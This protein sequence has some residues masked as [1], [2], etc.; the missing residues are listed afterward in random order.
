VIRT[1][2][3][4]ITTLYF[5]NL[6]RAWSQNGY[7]AKIFPELLQGIL[8]MLGL[9]ALDLLRLEELLADPNAPTLLW[10][11]GS[12]CTG[13]SVSFLNYIET[14][15]TGPV[16]AADV[17]IKKVNLA[18]HQTV[19]DVSGETAVNV[20]DSVYASNNYYLVVEGG[21]PSAYGGHTCLAWTRNGNTDVT[22]LEAVRALAGR[23]LGILSIGT[24]ASWGGVS[25]AAPNL[26][27]VQGVGAAT[28]KPTVNIAGCPPHPNW[29][30]WGIVRALTGTVGTLDAYRRP[31]Q[32]YRSRVHDRCPR[33]ER[34]EAS[35]YGQ[36]GRC[37]EE[38]G[39]LGPACRA[40]SR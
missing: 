32:L 31:T 18:F 11:Q 28:G 25:A 26:T 20:V 24:C 17:L 39:C 21:V 8:M 14:S 15:T 2:A 22:F 16:T 19:M 34:E 4:A 13:C 5:T 37:L 10:L 35:T 1:R 12:G 30:V 40:G 6:S 27:G 3:M 7:I 38:L 23:A 29:I 33:R 9:S 36:D